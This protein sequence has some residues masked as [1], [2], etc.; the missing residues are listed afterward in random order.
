MTQGSIA[1]ADWT[2]HLARCGDA[3]YL[4]NIERSADLLFA[5]DRAPA[6]RL[7]IF[8]T[9]E[10]RAY[11]ARGRS[12]V[13]RIGPRIIGFVIAE[14]TGREL[15]IVQMAVHAD[16]Q[17]QGIGSGMIRALIVDSTNSGFDALTLTTF[18][19]IA[20]N[21][22]FYAGLGF[23]AVDDMEANPRLKALLD[24][25]SASGLPVERRTAM[26]RFLH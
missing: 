15:H 8:D 14:P 9:N 18:A 21:A 19:D 13:V 2:L 17:R 7:P 26:I 22:P 3:E 20:W 11:I 5:N 16:F 12:L 10:L 25:E 4:P 1:A 24:A 6:A 23:V